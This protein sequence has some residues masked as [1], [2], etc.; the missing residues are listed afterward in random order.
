MTDSQLRQHCR[1]LIETAEAAY[2][3]TIDASGCPHIRAVSNLRR[4]QEFPGLAPLFQPHQDDFL[5]YIATSASSDKIQ[6]VRANPA[7]CVYYCVPG[8]FHGVLLEGLLEI[9]EDLELKRAL[10]QPRWEIFWTGGPEDP[11]YAALRL[12]PRRAS[13]WW[14]DRTFAFSLAQA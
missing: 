7:G 13:G 4:K 1:E 14:E 9:A 12:R 8:Q 6:Q 5:I 10:W 2:L 11:D 3:G